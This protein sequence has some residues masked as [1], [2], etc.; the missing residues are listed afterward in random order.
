MPGAPCRVGPPGPQPGAG[1]A[2]HDGAALIQVRPNSAV[3]RPVRLSCSTV[4]SDHGKLRRRYGGVCPLRSV[5]AMDFCPPSAWN[6]SWD[7]APNNPSAVG[8]ISAMDCAIG[9]ASA[10]GARGRTSC[11]RQVSGSIPLTG[12]QVREGV[13]P[14]RAPGGVRGTNDAGRIY[15]CC[16]DKGHIE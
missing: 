12:S 10:L 9:A 5:T 11:K 4:L 13:Y 16:T 15:A 1:A 8:A 3:Q 2:G 14:L 7:G 6:G